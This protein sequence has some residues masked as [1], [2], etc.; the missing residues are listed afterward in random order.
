MDDPDILPH[1]LRGSAVFLFRA[2]QMIER[3]TEALTCLAHLILPTRY[4]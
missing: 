1:R 4:L 2:L 3:R